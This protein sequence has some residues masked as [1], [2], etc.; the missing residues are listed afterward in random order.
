MDNT[1]FLNLCNE[2]KFNAALE[3]LNQA[4]ET[5]R[6]AKWYANLSYL[7]YAKK[8]PH[9]ALNNVVHALTMNPEEPLAHLVL[10]LCLKLIGGQDSA[11]L[12][13]LNKALSHI[14]PSLSLS[15][16]VFELESSIKNAEWAYQSY[17]ERC[18]NAGIEAHTTLCTAFSYQ[19][20][21]ENFINECI[22]KR[23]A[24]R[25]AYIVP[26][27][28]DK[29]YRSEVND[30]HLDPQVLLK[31]NDA[32]V[33]GGS[34]VVLA[35]GNSIITS[36]ASN[37]R[38]WKN[39]NPSADPKIFG[40]I[41]NLEMIFINGDDVAHEIELA[42]SLLGQG[43][44]AFG[45]W[46]PD[47]L[48]RLFMFLK[49]NLDPAVPIL[50]DSNMPKTHIEYINIICGNPVLQL[51]FGAPLLVR[52]LYIASPP[53]LLPLFH[54]NL[55]ILPKQYESP[56]SPWVLNRF[57]E[58]QLQPDHNLPKKIYLSRI[59]SR[60]GGVLNEFEVRD[61]VSEYG[62][63]P[64]CIEEYSAKE[65]IQ[66]VQNASH[67]VVPAGS[68]I[69]LCSMCKSDAKVLFLAHGNPFSPACW[70]SAF[71]SIDR[72]IKYWPAQLTSPDESKHA[73]MTVSINGLD[74]FLRNNL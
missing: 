25:Y 4:P 73:D 20:Y 64:I 21:A 52:T 60:W 44:N 42:F 65:Q 59:N 72:E 68:A 50:V 53:C 6:G 71:R 11:A 48:G 5:T 28:F 69:L 45:H 33:F 15:K 36:Y 35:T 57:S 66:L 46:F 1:N 61:K 63:V 2:A 62:F 58:I 10:G 8:N 7:E 22:A 37:D 19:R 54:Q 34:D 32:K 41:N 30:I 39:I 23:D 47:F 18:T 70:N 55:D 49:E 51:P 9:S 43:S 3:Y 40:R 14:P 17:L 16:L 12:F 67:I 13:H 31:I 74:S 38:F 56:I 24:E 27:C 26:E 29:K